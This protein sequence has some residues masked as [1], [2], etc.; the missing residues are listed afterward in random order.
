MANNASLFFSIPT[1]L[2]AV[3]VYTTYSLYAREDVPL[4]SYNEI[5]VPGNG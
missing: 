3:Q 4:R 2:H 1:I 5:Q